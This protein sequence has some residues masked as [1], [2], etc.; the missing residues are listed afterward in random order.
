ML[1]A[2]TLKGIRLSTPGGKQ[3][4][5]PLN[6][7]QSTSSCPL[8]C[9]TSSVHKTPQHT[10]LLQ[11]QI[12]DYVVE[13]NEDTVVANIQERYDLQSD[14]EGL[15]SVWLPP[16]AKVSIHCQAPSAASWPEAAAAP[17][18]VLDA[19]RQVAVSARREQFVGFE[20]QQLAQVQMYLREFGTNAPISGATIRF[21]MTHDE[22]GDDVQMA[23]GDQVTGDD[24]RTEWIK[25]HTGTLV[26]ADIV[27]LPGAAPPLFQLQQAGCGMIA[28][29]FQLFCYVQTPWPLARIVRCK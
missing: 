11:A 27:H 19:H 25:G 28:C 24:G 26:R 18:T 6:T 2:D 16:G 3:I 22:R 4:A 7:D 23:L 17:L 14:A 12:V 13:V 9:T 8:Q 20:L 29:H 5:N 1:I 10:Q 21:V 15:A